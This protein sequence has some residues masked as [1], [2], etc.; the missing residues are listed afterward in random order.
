VWVLDALV[1]VAVAALLVGGAVVV[2]D[3]PGESAL[4]VG[5]AA[6]LIGSAVALFWRRTHPIPAGLVSGA[7]AVAYGVAEL[8]DPPFPVAAIVGI[9]SVS[10]WCSRR[11]TVGA[12]ALVAAAM[13]AGLLLTRDSGADDYYRNLIPAVAA[14]ALGDQVRERVRAE[15]R[16]RRADLD[17]AVRAERSRLARELH[18]VVA[19]HVVMVVVGAEAGA[20]RRE[21]HGDTEGAEAFDAVAGS[22][23]DALGDLRLLLDVLRDG[24]DGPG[25]APQPGLADVPAL[26]ARVRAVGVPVELAEEGDRRPLPPG[27]DLSAYRIVQEALTN[28]VRH[29]GPVST[30]VLVRWADAGLTV[31]VVDDGPIAVPSI[32]PGRGLVG[33]GE[34]VALL[35]G[36]ATMGPRPTGGFEVSA[37]IPVSAVPA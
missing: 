22:A 9:Y 26:V 17:D 10:R 37:T 8:P 4:T 6:L 19:H 34:R 11:T 12:A 5:G 27:A 21:Q 16:R 1:V 30:H 36:H 3:D 7:F 20:A 29:A 31:A 33:I 14:L 2:A 32:E 24:D 25:T 28:V 15:G 18:D 35:G 13:L 23:R